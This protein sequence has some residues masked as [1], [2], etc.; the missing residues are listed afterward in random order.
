MKFAKKRMLLHC[1]AKFKIQIFCRYS[2]DMEENADSILRAP[3]LI[4]LHV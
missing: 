1:L 2:A 4:T 3:I